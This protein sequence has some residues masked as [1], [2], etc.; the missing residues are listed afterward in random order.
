[1]GRGAD[2]AGG[3]VKDEIFKVHELAVDPQRGAGIGEISPL[4]EAGANRRTGDAL[5]ETGERNASVESR[6]RQGFNGDFRENI[7]H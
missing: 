2:V 5:I 6:P 3:V 1:M 4:E 7:S